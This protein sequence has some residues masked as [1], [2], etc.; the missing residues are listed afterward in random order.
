MYDTVRME[1]GEGQDYIVTNIYLDVEREWFL[2][3]LQES[4]QTTIHE[5]H[6]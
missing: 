5:F 3:L 1:V 2:G 4:G 6:V